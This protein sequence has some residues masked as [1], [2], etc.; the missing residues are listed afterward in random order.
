MSSLTCPV[1]RFVKTP[2]GAGR[3]GPSFQGSRGSGLRLSRLYRPHP[4][5]RRL[6]YRLA[7]LPSA[8][9]LH[10]PNHSPTLS[11]M[12]LTKNAINWFEIPVTDFERAQKFYSAIF[13]YQ[14]PEMPMGPFR[15]G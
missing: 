12:E 13:D 11:P 3:L 2:T 7:R 4:P 15:M 9:Y 8:A 6:F 1:F 14:M 10:P 5:D